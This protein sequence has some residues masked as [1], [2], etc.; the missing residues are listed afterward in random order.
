[1]MSVK[2]KIAK[3]HETIRSC[4]KCP[5]HKGRKN[6]VPGEGSIDTRLAFIGEA[7]GK[8][9]DETGRP[10]VGRSGK[11]LTDLI[12]NRLPCSRKDV[13]IT[14]VIKCRP[15][16]NRT[17]KNEEIE[18]CVPYLE[19]Q[20]NLIKPDIV[21][22]LGGVAISTLLGYTTVSS[23]HGTFCDDT[24]HRYFMTYHPAAALRFSKYKRLIEEDFDQLA[25]ELM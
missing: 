7:P 1:M 21:V 9:E 17:P 6:A 13:F 8:R 22:L 15:P 5:L 4:T 23:V 16:N 3:L 12:E 2:K 19:E 14:S 20:L 18:T 24:N 10:F 25:T 11:L